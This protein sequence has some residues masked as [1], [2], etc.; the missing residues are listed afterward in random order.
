MREGKRKKGGEAPGKKLLLGMG[1]Q[2]Q[3]GKKKGRGTPPPKQKRWGVM[4]KN[5]GPV[6][7]GWCGPARFCR[8]GDRET[9]GRKRE[10][11]KKEN[12]PSR[13]QRMCRKERWQ[14]AVAYLPRPSPCPNCRRGREER[15]YPISTTARGKKKKKCPAIRR[16]RGDVNPPGSCSIAEEGEGK[17]ES[18]ADL[19]SYFA[20]MRK[21]QEGLKY[22][23]YFSSNRGGKKKKGRNPRSG[24]H[25]ARDPKIMADCA[26]TIAPDWGGKKREE[27][28]KDAVVDIW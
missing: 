11:K 1:G 16:D 10:K 7:G 23:V 6:N 25:P 21:Q 12:R 19:I 28:G 5:S 26:I 22:I 8:P 13:L 18:N 20:P 9:R 4:G 2:F 17:K 27:G 3:C 24:R 14:Q 15:G